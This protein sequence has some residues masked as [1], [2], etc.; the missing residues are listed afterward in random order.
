MPA[1]CEATARTRRDSYEAHF[2]DVV[3]ALVAFARADGE[4]GERSARTRDSAKELRRL[5]REALER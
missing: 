2:R 4:L 5:Y 3:E 1:T